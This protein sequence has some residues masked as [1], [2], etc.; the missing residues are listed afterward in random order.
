MIRKW[1][2]QECWEGKFQL[3]RLSEMKLKT[4]GIKSL[5]VGQESPSHPLFFREARLVGPQQA[6]LKADF[7]H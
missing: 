7:L 5:G 2:S 4:M 3:Q 1:G 6:A